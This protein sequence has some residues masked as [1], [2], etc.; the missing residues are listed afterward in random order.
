VGI[1]R[2]EARGGDID[3]LSQIN[4]YL[5]VG[6]EVGHGAQVQDPLEERGSQWGS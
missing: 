5:L 6:P 3:A 4:K 1:P 2:R